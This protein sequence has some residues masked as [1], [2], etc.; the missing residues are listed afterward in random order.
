ML[1]HQI[2][3]PHQRSVSKQP[4][5]TTVSAKWPQYRATASLICLDPNVLRNYILT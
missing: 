2:L 4:D 5:I 1:I 3:L